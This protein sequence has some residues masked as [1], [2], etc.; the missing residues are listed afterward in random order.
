MAS[1][2]NRYIFNAELEGFVRMG[3]PGG[4]FNNCSFGFTLPDRV[5]AQAEEDR[6]ELL[7]WARS[8]VDDPK[9]LRRMVVNPPQ[10]DEEGLVKYSYLGETS[11]VEPTIVDT[12]GEVLDADTIKQIGQGTKVRMVVR[13]RPYTKP[14]LGTSLVVEGLMVLELKTFSGL[15]DAGE[16]EPDELMDLLNGDDEDDE[17]EAPRR[18]KK[19]GFKASNPNPRKA[20]DDDKEEEGYA[21]Y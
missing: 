11:K 8:K 9:K 10:W 20:E 15:S 18:S 13:Q 1:K 17:D 12:E 19:R 4:K 14:T 5:I 3:K 21:D 2:K 7:K 6:E 16:L